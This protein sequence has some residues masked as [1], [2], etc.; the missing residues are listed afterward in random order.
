MSCENVAIFS[1]DG[2]LF[3][4]ESVA[5]YELLHSAETVSPGWNKRLVLHN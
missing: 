5:D 3:E 4:I 1:H 2:M